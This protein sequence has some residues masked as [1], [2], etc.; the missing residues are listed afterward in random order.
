MKILIIGIGNPG[1]GDD[2]LGPAL[3]ARMAATEPDAMPEGV[4]IVLPGRPAAAVWKYQLNIEDAFLIKDYETAVFADASRLAGT[5][6]RLEEIAAAA[7]IAFTTHEMS[8]AAVLALCEHL[9]GRAPLGRQLS[10]PGF[11]WELGDG[12]SAEAVLNLDAAAVRLLE[13]L[14]AFR[15]G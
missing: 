1:R 13:F 9:Y 7:S 2:G 14:E 10:I 15:R 6:V 8:P 11:S 5:S 4:V 12:L 3:A